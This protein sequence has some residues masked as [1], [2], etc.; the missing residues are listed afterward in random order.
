MPNPSNP[1]L[2]LFLN[3]LFKLEELQIPYMVIGGFAAT[4]Y[5][6]TR[7][8]VDIDIVVEMDAQQIEALAAVYDESRY[9]ADADQMRRAVRHGTSFNIAVCSP[10]SRF[11]NFVS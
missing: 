10:V 3:I 9:Y 6:I 2:L 5:G 7:I 11:R 1:D 8:T 4:L